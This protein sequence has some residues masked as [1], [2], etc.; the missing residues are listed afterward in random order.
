M[1]VTALNLIIAAQQARAGGAMQRPGGIPAA[2][3]PRSP[4]ASEPQ[5][6]MDTKTFAP[7]ASRPPDGA[8]PAAQSSANP[9]STAA[10]PGSQLDIRV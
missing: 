6:P 3:Q 10:P 2:A 5:V 9:G 8:A 7:T 1:Q 4:S